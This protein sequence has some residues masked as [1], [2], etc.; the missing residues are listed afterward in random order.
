MSQVEEFLTPEEEQEIVLA[1]RKAELNTSGEIR[2][3]LEEEAKKEVYKRATEVF[4]ELKME[5][6][7]LRNGVLI[8]V[9]VKDKKFVIIGDKGINEV[10]PNNFWDVTRDVIQEEFKKGD[11]KQGIIDGV[12][13]TGEQLKQFFPW[14]A[15]DINELSDQISKG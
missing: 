5:D 1:I 8:Y 3:H 6:T 11:F 14:D 15:S 7:E 10:I 13:K 9:A 4:F 2:V 12:L